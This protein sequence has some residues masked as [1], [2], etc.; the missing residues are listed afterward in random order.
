MRESVTAVAALLKQSA[1]DL[2]SEIRGTSMMPALPAGVRIRI[3]CGYEPAIGDIAAYYADAPIIA[4]RVIGRISTGG[5]SYYMMRGDANWFCDAPIEQTRVLGVVTEFQ[6]GTTWRPAPPNA[7]DAP[8]V[9]AMTAISYWL[10]VGGLAI[11]E[12]TAFRV[13]QGLFRF[14]GLLRRLRSRRVTR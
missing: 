2:E 3:R 11:R 7:P 9:R 1:T 10:I 14:A 4:H 12:R 8:L 13:S 6:D 5:G